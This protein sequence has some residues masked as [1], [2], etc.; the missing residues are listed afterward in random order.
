MLHSVSVT[1]C[2]TCFSEIVQADRPE[3]TPGGAVVPDSP[4]SGQDARHEKVLRVQVRLR[5]RQKAQVCFL[6]ETFVTLQVTY[7]R[8]PGI[9][10]F[11]NFK[12]LIHINYNYNLHYTDMGFLS[13]LEASGV[14]LEI[15]LKRTGEF[16]GK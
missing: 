14:I 10:L 2:H 8:K 12:I 1:Q 9:S 3:G 4:Q 7:I 16:W 6:C 15:H 5:V 11:Q 13:F